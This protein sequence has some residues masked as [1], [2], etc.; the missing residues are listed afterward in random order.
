MAEMAGERS[1]D[2]CTFQRVSVGR[3]ALEGNVITSR[4]R[5]EENFMFWFGN[6]EAGAEREKSAPAGKW[7]PWVAAL[8]LASPSVAHAQAGAPAGPPGGFSGERAETGASAGTLDYMHDLEKFAS[9]GSGSPEAKSFASR[10]AAFLSASSERRKEAFALGMAAQRGERVD[11][12]AGTL[13][14]ELETDLIAWRDAFQIQRREYRAIHDKMLGGGG[15]LTP[16]QWAL[17]RAGWFQA[18]DQWVE[19]RKQQLGIAP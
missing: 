2:F 19:Q 7:L 3:Y 17:R 12:P 16:A 15:D 8:V 13:R 5:R 10:A 1:E 14:K 9:E 18:R 4:T 6:G 11:V